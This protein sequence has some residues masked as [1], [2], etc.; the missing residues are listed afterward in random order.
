M[1]T[2]QQEMDAR[3]RVALLTTSWPRDDADA[4]GRFLANQV[5]RIRAA[6]ALVQVVAPKSAIRG[7]FDDRGLAGGA[8][9]V[10]NAKRRPWRVPRLLLAMVRS[11]RRAA[12]HSDVVHTNWLL[13][14]PIAALSGKPVV[15]TLHGSGTAGRFEDLRIAHDFPR[16]FRWLI[17]KAT[18][19]VGVSPLLADAARAAGARRVVEIPHGVDVP[20][21]THEP[22]PGSSGAGDR[23]QLPTVLFAGRLSKEKG[24][25]LL[26]EVFAGLTDRLQL[27]V[28][29]DGPERGRVERIPHVEVL[30][31]L[32][33]DA[34]DAA[35]RRADVLVMPSQREGFGVVA[36]E[37]MAHGVPVVASR[38]GGLQR[39]IEHDVTGLL[40][41]PG[42]AG[43]LRA[44]VLRLLDDAGLRA[45]LGDAAR[46]EAAANYSWPRV[47]AALV[48]A[49]RA[50]ASTEA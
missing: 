35:Y 38:V 26:A 4:T 43:E 37:A 42:D 18:V 8:G 36:L 47:T 6:G 45:R 5:E 33:R 28:A 7:G 41:A 50:A 12:R 17:R 44:A 19:V 1:P 31:M 30:G 27:V 34:L 9:I 15:L 21:R 16:L 48:E 40:V 24:T 20:E 25:A 2:P 10:A 3:L 49:Y 11:I 39:L 23:A 46:A 13:T 22:A 32:D 29:G 14:A